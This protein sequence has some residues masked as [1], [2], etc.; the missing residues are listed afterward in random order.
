MSSLSQESGQS[1]RGISKRY[2][3]ILKWAHLLPGSLFINIP[4]FVKTMFRK[5]YALLNYLQNKRLSLF[6][7]SFIAMAVT[8]ATTDPLKHIQAIFIFYIGFFIL[9]YLCVSFVLRIVFRD[10]DG[11]A[12]RRYATAAGAFVTVASMLK[13]TGSLSLRDVLILGFI[14]VI[15][16]LYSG[17]RQNQQSI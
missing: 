6:L 15:W 3:L 14:T 16:A 5:V 7:F 10:M 11:S 12:Q 17:F 4:N 8:M 9:I 1:S 13:S 2:K